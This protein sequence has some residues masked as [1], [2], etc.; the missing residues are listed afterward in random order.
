MFAARNIMFANALDAD[1]QAFASAS[2]AT[3]L[4]AHNAL[5]AYLK[6]QSLYQHSR[7][8]SFKSAQ[9]NGSGSTVNC[10]GGWTTNN[11]ILVGSPPWAAGDMNF[12]GAGRYAY[13]DLPGFQS[14]S[15]GFVMT[16]FKPK[17]ASAPDG[18]AFARWWFGDISSNRFLASTTT[19]GS[20][21]GE[22][23]ATAQQDGGGADR[24]GSSTFTWTAN[25]D[26]TEVCK[27]GTFGS[28]AGIWKNDAAITMSLSSGSQVF[29]PAA[30]GYAT[31]DRLYISAS[32]NTTP[33]VSLTG[34]WI[35]QF[36]CKVT[37]TTAQREAIRGLLAAF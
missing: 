17:D 2:G 18:G 5:T 10:L 1:V 19:T 32:F 31:N 4:Y 28:T 8:G 33:S 11:I 6:S 16:R 24:T 34:S 20:L 22:T 35:V 23:Y 30:T 12:N 25:E 27:F 29:T 37:L 21:S 3:D 7:W 13:I 14:L 9:A 36:F 26:F 15:D